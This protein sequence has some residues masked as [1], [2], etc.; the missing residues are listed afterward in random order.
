MKDKVKSEETETP[1]L[2]ELLVITKSKLPCLNLIFHS[3]SIIYHLGNSLCLKKGVKAWS[4]FAYLPE[5]CPWGVIC[6]MH[7]TS[8]GILEERYHSILS[9]YDDGKS[10]RVVLLV[11]IFS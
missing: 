1:N 11:E 6:L 5:Q 9:G 4:P 8:N 7:K 2:S 10:Y 3:V